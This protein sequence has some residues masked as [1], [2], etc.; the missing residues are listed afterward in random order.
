MKEIDDIIE[1][2]QETT[3]TRTNYEGRQD[4]S[5]ILHSFENEKEQAIRVVLLEWIQD[6]FI[7]EHKENAALRQKVV[8]LEEM[9]RKSTFQ[10][11]VDKEDIKIC[12]VENCSEV[13]F[14]R[15]EIK[16]IVEHVDFLLNK[17]ANC[18]CDLNDEVLNG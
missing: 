5:P 3:H 18:K 15:G 6:H 8:F 11:F 12:D 2:L 10:P 16:S 9:T 4:S 7:N 13:S 14:L 1:R 17:L